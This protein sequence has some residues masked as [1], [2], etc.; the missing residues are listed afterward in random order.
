MFGNQQSLIFSHFMRIHSCG[1]YSCMFLYLAITLFYAAEAILWHLALLYQV[2]LYSPLLSEVVWEFCVYQDLTKSLILTFFKFLGG[3]WKLPVLLSENRETLLI[4]LTSSHI[5]KKLL[6][7]GQ[8]KW[9]LLLMRLD[10]GPFSKFQ[11]RPQVE[12]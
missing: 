2:F 9:Y 11:M 4:F 3:K 8:C 12:R 10:S 1:G 5:S 7:E 6:C